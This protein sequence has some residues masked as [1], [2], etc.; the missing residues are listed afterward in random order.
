[1]AINHVL[2]SLPAQEGA[3]DGDPVAILPFLLSIALKLLGTVVA[4]LVVARPPTTC[5]SMRN[6]T[7]GKRCRGRGSSKN[8]ARPRAIRPSRPTPA[9]CMRPSKSTGNTAGALPRRCRKHR[10]R[11]AAAAD[12][13][14]FAAAV[15]G[16]ANRANWLARPRR[17]GR[18][19]YTTPLIPTKAG[20]Q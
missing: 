15:I 9:P 5:S 4:V 7:R 12:G 10:L 8:S 17:K 1:M 2:G 16:R 20:I 13:G 14:S 6:G 3:D 11:H 18:E 19:K